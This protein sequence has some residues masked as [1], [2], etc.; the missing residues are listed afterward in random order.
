MT[1]T[2]IRALS[3]RAVFKTVVLVTSACLW[4]AQAAAA[5]GLAHVRSS[6]SV[7][8]GVMEDAARRSPA[9]EKLVGVINLTDGIVYVEEGV[10]RH[11]VR[12]CLMHSVTAVAGFRFL[13]I[14]I[15]LR[16]TSSYAARLDL[17]GTIGHELW[18]AMEVLGDKTLTT[19]AAIF[20]YYASAAPT[21]NDS[22][23]TP[24]AVAMGL[25]I[26]VEVERGG[27]TPCHLGRAGCV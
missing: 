7:I 9:F 6:S 22:V 18:H 23:E 24:S 20:F 16:S 13:R 1:L 11:G 27:T 10:C 3:A 14:L 21:A 17:M 2:S 15:D 26:R 8:R 5:D 4:T 19:A 25:V 12:A